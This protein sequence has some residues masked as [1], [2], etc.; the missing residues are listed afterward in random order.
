MDIYDI[1]EKYIDRMIDIIEY[2]NVENHDDVIYTMGK[3]KA[4]ANLI[5]EIDTC[6]VITVRGKE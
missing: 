4:Y 1:R 6:K 3:L 5:D 2:V